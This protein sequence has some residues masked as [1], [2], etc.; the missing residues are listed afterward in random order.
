MKSA[1]LP[2]LLFSPSHA[3]IA[4][5]IVTALPGFVNNTW[6]FKLYSGLLNVPGP[7]NGYDSLLIH[8]QFHT[9]RKDA[10]RDPVVTWH[11]G[12]PGGSSINTGLYGEMGAFTVGDNG[13]YLNP[14]AWNR[15]ANMLYLDSPA[16]SGGSHGYSQCIKAGYPV[17]CKWN[18]KSQAE[19]YAHT[20][21]AFYRG[22]P[23]FQKND[24][25]MTGESYAGQYVPNIAHFIL[26]NFASQIPL[27]GIALGNACWGGNSTCVVCNGPSE[28]KLDVE[29]LFGH[30]MF[31]PKLHAEI[32]KECV[33]PTEYTDC[34]N[35]D[36]DE[37]AGHKVLSA[38][39]KSLLTNMR[40]QAGPYDVYYLY[41]NCPQTNEF[42]ERTGKDMNWLTTYLRRGMHN[43]HGT[44]E[45]L[46][47]MNGGYK[48]DCGGDE[49]AWITRSD[50]RKALHLDSV[51]PGASS[52]DYVLSGP[53]SITLYPE[54]VKKLR[55]L[56]YNGQ[57]D[58]CVPYI[59]N[60][61]WI[62]LLESQG[63]LQETSPWTPWFTTSKR[64]A[65]GYS[66]SYSVTGADTDFKFQTVRLAGHMVPQFAP[67][68]GFTLFS[69]FVA[70]AK[71]TQVV[72]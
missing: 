40:K 38:K 34:S 46:I 19:A 61:D 43:P 63:I 24:L 59:G 36:A 21:M 41:D 22:F 50:V 45:S 17:P 72:V 4:A 56:I 65:A 18:D 57:A 14:W 7:I 55:V 71:T 37:P 58:G 48:W 32:Q 47:K 44:H 11:Q 27:R 10:A 53:A 51:T 3:E 23:E 26:N 33:F 31:S 52:F 64:T 5:D 28:D 62:A 42:L 25:Y 29:L 6:P 68:A 2:L 16:G 39:C 49:G 70:G 54:L 30:G 12:G 35:P 69:E 66:T 1:I 20:L 8:Y 9:S 60:E 15:V 13:N 67:E